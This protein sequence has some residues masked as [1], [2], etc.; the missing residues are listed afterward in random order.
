M[1]RYVQA[2]SIIN[3]A[4]SS[5]AKYKYITQIPSGA[6]FMHNNPCDLKLIVSP[7][8]LAKY[9][10]NAMYIKVT[11]EFKKY[12][13]IEVDS[14]GFL[15]AKGLKP[16][17]K[18]KEMI[19][20]WIESGCTKV[21]EQLQTVDGRKMWTKDSRPTWMAEE[22]RFR[23]INE[24]IFYMLIGDSKIYVS[25]VDKLPQYVDDS[26]ILYREYSDKILAESEVLDFNNFI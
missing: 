4:I 13:S 15:I 9:F 2:M 22:Y 3:A 8:Y 17:Y 21:I 14:Y 18:H 23:P 1:E 20:E 10:K 11:Y 12:N 7:E 26:L 25:P 16:P 24:V 6:I 5:N 19:D